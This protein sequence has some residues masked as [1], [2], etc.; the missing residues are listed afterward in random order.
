MM[1]KPQ[2]LLACY[3]SRVATEMLANKDG[4]HGFLLGCYSFTLPIMMLIPAITQVF[5]VVSLPAVT[6][7][8]TKK[9]KFELKKSIESV[10]KMTTL[11]TIPAGIGIALLGP[12]LLSIIY[13]HKP[14]EVQIASHIVPFLGIAT[15]LTATSTPL[16]S[17]LQAV[18]RV[19]LPVK[20]ISI[21]LIIKIIV[22]YFLVGIPSVNIQ[23]AGIGTIVGYALVLLVCT[24]C[25]IKETKIVPDFKQTV[26]KPLSA[27]LICCF[28]G[29][30]M[31]SFLANFSSKIIAFA[32]AVIFAI[33]VYFI[34]LFL[35]KVATFDDIKSLPKGEYLIKFYYNLFERKKSKK[36]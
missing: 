32:S 11:V 28:T 6:A 26:L 15:S 27:A 16:C 1:T 5:G 21:G 4:V 25:L 29:Y 10:I 14:T 34:S 3:G 9:N 19:D 36:L 31:N 8:Y 17:M 23:G 33:F 35:L 20:I 22:N 13:P 18:G 7:A 12:T 24:R 30:F 2:E